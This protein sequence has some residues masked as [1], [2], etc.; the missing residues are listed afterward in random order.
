[1]FSHINEAWNYDP[2]KEITNKLSRGSFRTNTDQSEVFNF[3]NQ[4][5]INSNDILSLSDENSLNLLSEDTSYLNTIDSDFCSYAPVNFD[6][7]PYKKKQNKNRYS[8]KYDSDTNP[9]LSD[10]IDTSR[11]NYSIKHLKK[12]D[13]CYDKLKNLINNKVNKKFDEIILDTKMKQLQNPSSMSQLP[14]LQQ[15]IA[16]PQSNHSD[17]WKETLIIVIGA[18]IAMFII[19]LIVKAI[20]K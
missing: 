2:V 14:I 19:F 5:K 6:K 3:K 20:H 17:S 12:C 16:I 15:P 18:I 8:R 13:R 10:S 9:S 11:C 1:M 4:S 7:Y